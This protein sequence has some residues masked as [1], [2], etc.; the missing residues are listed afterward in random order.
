MDPDPSISI[1][2]IILIPLVLAFNLLLAGFFYLLKNEELKRL[3]LVN[4]ILASI[5]M[6][7]MFINGISRHLQKELECWKFKKADTTF[8]LI[9]WKK[10]NN[11]DFEY[12]TQ[13]GSSTVFLSGVYSSENAAYILTT[14]STKY[15][16]KGDCLIGFR[17]SKDTIKVK[18]IRP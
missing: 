4:S 8:S 13:A 17:E 5:I 3:F 18:K 12:S 11:F 15:L 2:L 6:Y 16:I 1:G 9:R 7:Y 10:T 14:D